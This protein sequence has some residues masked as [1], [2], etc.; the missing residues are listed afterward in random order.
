MIF[1]YAAIDFIPFIK[2]EILLIN[3][4]YF[5]PARTQRHA[6]KVFVSWG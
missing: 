6:G 3:N 2:L 4:C 1:R 5:A